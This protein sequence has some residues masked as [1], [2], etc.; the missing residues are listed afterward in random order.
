MAS[1]TRKVTNVREKKAIKA[2][3]ARKNLLRIHGSTAKNLP[4]N[5]PNAHEKAAIAL[6]AKASASAAK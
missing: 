5:M 6:K 2:G 3:A 4:L 1:R